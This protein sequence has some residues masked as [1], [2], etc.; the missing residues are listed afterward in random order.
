M[1]KRQKFPA[2]ASLCGPSSRQKN[3]G[4]LLAA[5]ILS[6][7]Y[8][9]NFINFLHLGRQ[10]V[11]AQDPS[12]LDLKARTSPLRGNPCAFRTML[13]DGAS[14]RDSI[15]NST[16]DDMGNDSIRFDDSECISIGR[17][18]GNVSNQQQQLQKRVD[19]GI[20]LE[21]QGRNLY[22][23]PADLL[24]PGN[25][26][27]DESA[28]N[29]SRVEE[30][31][32]MA[33][34]SP[35]FTTEH[36]PFDFSVKAD[37]EIVDVIHSLAPITNNLSSISGFDNQELDSMEAMNMPF[38]NG[39]PRQKRHQRFPF[40]DHDAANDED[41]DMSIVSDLSL[42]PSY[43]PGDID[44]QFNVKITRAVFKR[45]I[46]SQAK[47]ASKTVRQIKRTCRE[48]MEHAFDHSTP[49]YKP[50]TCVRVGDAF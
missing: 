37:D 4:A 30:D 7:M 49:A 34:C 32:E 12:D 13:N 20:A 17:T 43:S 11:A 15:A 50:T 36:R 47:A 10:G 5:R 33:I 3:L 48:A 14:S 24:D 44:R 46:K 21:T 40:R 39:T 28:E 29:N 38:W 45:L 25:E 26:D 2:T 19:S 16:Y 35:I 27:D 22:S 41:D 9:G 1:A 18:L 23:V 6:D 31:V 8:S 42:I